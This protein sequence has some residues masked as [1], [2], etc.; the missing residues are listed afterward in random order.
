VATDSAAIR[1]PEP[2]EACTMA[3]VGGLLMG[4]TIPQA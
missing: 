4:G 3:I 1:C 2:T